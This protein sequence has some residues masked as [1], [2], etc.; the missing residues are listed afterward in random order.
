MNQR[1]RREGVAGWRAGHLRGGQAA[2]VGV[3]ERQKA[4][5]RTGVPG[6]HRL[7]HARDLTAG[8]V[9]RANTP[10]AADVTPRNGIDAA[11]TL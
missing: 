2:Q 6:V 1:G 4:I 5:G 9:H 7:Q 8:R 11:A 3:H 10:V